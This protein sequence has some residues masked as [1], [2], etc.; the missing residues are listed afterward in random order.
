MV[1][2]SI[3]LFTAINQKVIVSGSILTLLLFSSSSQADV[4]VDSNTPEEISITNIQPNRYTYKIPESI[5]N[6]KSSVYLLVKPKQASNLPFNEEV[7]VAANATAISP[8]LIHAI[9][10]VESKHNPFARSNK[11]A[12][13]LMQLMP[14]TAMR[15]NVSN[16]KD[17]RQNILAGAKYLRELFDLFN[18]DIRLTVAAYN[19]G[20]GA[21]QKYGGKIPPYK[22]TMN[23]VPKV[24]RY[25]KLYS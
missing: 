14:S 18:G 15:F 4:Y 16:K 2:E 21:V 12:Y 9:I 8:A 7:M 1:I 24:L 25:Y 11:G 5:S 3:K 6:Y 23:Y 20:P 19:A 10:T 13:G 17:P 22:E